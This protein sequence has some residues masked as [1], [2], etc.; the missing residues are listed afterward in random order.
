MKTSILVSSDWH[1]GNSAGVL[2]PGT[3]LVYNDPGEPYKEYEPALTSAQDRIWNVTQNCLAYAEKKSNGGPV[4]SIVVGD[5][6]HGNR[7]VEM[8]VSSRKYHQ[9]EIAMQYFDALVKRLNITANYMVYGTD[10]H[11]DEGSAEVELAEKIRDKYEIESIAVSLLTLNIDGVVFDIAHDGPQ[12]GRAHTQGNPPRI[13]LRRAMSEDM[14][15]LNKQPADVYLRGHFHS[16][17]DELATLERNGKFYQSR[18]ITC[19]SMCLPNGYAR[20]AT[21]A[22]AFVRIGMIYCEVENGQ[23]VFVKPLLQTFDLR[24]RASVGTV[25]Y[26]YRGTPRE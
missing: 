21:R 9:A 19:P 26:Q 22:Q 6:Q 17:S 24:S 20:S 15:A 3:K 7:F 14:D 23:L 13:Y 16:F 5:V 2:A 25:F 12:A 18:I 4:I 10:V 1:A 8:L 11:T